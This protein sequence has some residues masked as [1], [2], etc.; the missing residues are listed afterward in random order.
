MRVTAATVWATIA[1]RR[2]AHT[3]RVA[4]RV[5][6]RVRMLR[7][8]AVGAGRVAVRGLRRDAPV[9]RGPSVWRA[10][11]VLGP[12]VVHGREAIDAADAAVVIVGVGR[13]QALLDTLAAGCRAGMGLEILE[14]VGHALFCRY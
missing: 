9:G 5:V 4:V 11:R 7:V 12:H 8:E 1:R 10:P 14:T 6:G 13:W 2:T 3:A